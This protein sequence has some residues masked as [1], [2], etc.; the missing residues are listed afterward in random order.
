VPWRGIAA[1]AQQQL[2]TRTKGRQLEVGM[3]V[4]A[5]AGMF[6]EVEPALKMTRI[7]PDRTS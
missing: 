7:R 4:A 1:N 2:V 6:A 5:I 3:P